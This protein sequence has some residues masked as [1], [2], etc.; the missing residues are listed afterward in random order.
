MDEE[1]YVPDGEFEEA[2]Q[3]EQVQ[4]L[5]AQKL[6]ELPESKEKDSPD[7]FSR[8]EILGNIKNWEKVKL[9]R[10]HQL[11]KACERMGLT[12]AKNFFSREEKK[13][14][15]ISRS[16]GGFQQR[17]LRTT[18]SGKDNFSDDKKKK[19]LPNWGWK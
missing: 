12:K 11:Q 3:M 1:N 14:L 18:L 13:T 9:I 4:R 2:P 8:E 17:I 19:W 7:M 15:N 10:L 16:V 6:L 5:V